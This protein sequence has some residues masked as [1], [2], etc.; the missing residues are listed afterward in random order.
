MFQHLSKEIFPKEI[1]NLATRGDGSGF[2]LQTIV[3]DCLLQVPWDMTSIVSSSNT[4]SRWCQSHYNPDQLFAVST[5]SMQFSIS[6]SS[7]K[8][9]MKLTILNCFY[10]EAATNNNL[11]FS[12]YMWRPSCDFVIVCTLSKAFWKKAILFLSLRLLVRAVTITKDH[13]AINW[14]QS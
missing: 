12:S 5:R 7:G 10:S 13:S 1:H 11:F 2:W 9:L 3:R 4:R 6:S 8:K 14:T